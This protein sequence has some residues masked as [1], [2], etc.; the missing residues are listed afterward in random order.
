[1]VTPEQIKSLKIF[2]IISAIMLLLAIPPIWP[3]GY[4]QILRWVVA[5]VAGFNVYIAYQL[6][7]KNWL[8]IMVTMVIVFNPIAPIHLTKEVWSVLD[9]VAAIL[10]FT[11]IGKLRNSK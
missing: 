4:F 5:G 3:Y 9:V 2:S 1:M 7:R 10:M 11:S 6:N 8:W